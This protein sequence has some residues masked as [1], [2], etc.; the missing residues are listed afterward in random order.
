ME[1][2]TDSGLELTKEDTLKQF[3][4]SEKEAQVNKTNLN[5]FKQTI[6]EHA[7]N[8]EMLARDDEADFFKVLKA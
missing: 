8:E 1:R 7:T 2:E 3:E 5:E 6:K 4:E